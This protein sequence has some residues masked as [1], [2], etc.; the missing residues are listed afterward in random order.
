MATI[1]RKVGESLSS[2]YREEH[3]DTVRGLPMSKAR[4]NRGTSIWIQ[5]DPWGLTEHHLAALIILSSRE[6][7]VISVWGP[8]H[9]VPPIVERKGG[10]PRDG[11][12][13]LKRPIVGQ[14]RWPT[15]QG[16]YWSL[17]WRPCSPWPWIMGRHWATLVIT[18]LIHCFPSSRAKIWT[19]ASHWCW[20]REKDFFKKLTLHSKLCVRSSCYGSA[21]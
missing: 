12:S 5:T 20:C 1:L 4:V 17:F 15:S 10:L 21:S 14:S 3:W 2:F 16:A 11:G 19:L 9:L 13:C 7:P 8:R 6:G 18:G